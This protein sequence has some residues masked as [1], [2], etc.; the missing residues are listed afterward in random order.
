LQ[1]IFECTMPADFKGGLIKQ[2]I[3]AVLVLF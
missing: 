1:K 3:Q 2:D